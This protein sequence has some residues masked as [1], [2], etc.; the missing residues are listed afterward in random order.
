MPSWKSGLAV[1]NW[2]LPL[3][4]PHRSGPLAQ[5]PAC[6]SAR[7]LPSLIFNQF[8]SVGLSAQSIVHIARWL[9]SYI[10]GLWTGAVVTYASLAVNLAVFALDRRADRNEALMAT[11][12]VPDAAVAAAAGDTSKVRCSPPTSPKMVEGSDAAKGGTSSCAPASTIF[13]VVDAAYSA[14]ASS[15]PP[16]SSAVGSAV[17]LEASI[18]MASLPAFPPI[19]A[20]P[21]P[22]VAAGDTTIPPQAPLETEAEAAALE[23]AQFKAEEDELM[24]GGVTGGHALTGPPTTTV[25]AHADCAGLLR[26]PHVPGDS[27]GDLRVRLLNDDGDGDSDLTQVEAES[28]TAQT[29]PPPPAP[30]PPPPPPPL[31]SSQ[32][33]AVARP[34]SVLRAGPRTSGLTPRFAALKQHPRAGFADADGSPATPGSS[35]VAGMQSPALP[36]ASLTALS[37]SGVPIAVTGTGGV[38]NTR[39]GRTGGG[40][41][42]ATA[43]ADERKG[44]AARAAHP[45]A[46]CISKTFIV[47]FRS[48]L[49]DTQRCAGCTSHGGESHIAPH[50]CAARHNCLVGQR[51]HART[52]IFAPVVDHQRDLVHQNDEDWSVW[53]GNQC[54]ATG[55]VYASGAFSLLI[56]SSSFG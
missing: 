22:S 31:T 52:G 48:A 35:L 11:F 37:P 39:D 29:P 38:G 47:P 5:L 1:V 44:G 43:S 49:A 20:S 55:N 51:K 17:M 4:S 32:G 41:A 18:S 14:V 50:A 16:F 45:V 40:V 56:F 24:L 36:A 26:S 21:V 23:R 2:L 28:A 42:A 46:S 54:V 15:I 12:L 19:A 9:G 8:V 53:V 27:S 25:V 7:R 3:G 30:P 33:M 34:A 10:G 13:T 6:R